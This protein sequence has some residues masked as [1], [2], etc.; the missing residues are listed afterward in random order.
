MRRILLAAGFLMLVTE[1]GQA[2]E[3]AVDGALGGLAGAVVLGPVGLVGGALIGAT[4]GPGISQSWG[5]SG[6]AHHPRR[7]HARR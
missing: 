6:H 1:A 4:A 7:R 3:R 5:L 2:Q